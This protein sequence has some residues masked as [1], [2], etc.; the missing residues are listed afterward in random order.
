M[1]W[2]GAVIPAHGE[3]TYLSPAFEERWFTQPCRS[4]DDPFGTELETARP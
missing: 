2:H 4:V 1:A 3:I